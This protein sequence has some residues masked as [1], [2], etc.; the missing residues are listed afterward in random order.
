MM[1]MTDIRA[2]VAVTMTMM[3][4]ACREAVAGA[5]RAAGSEI[6]KATPKPLAE[7]GRNAKAEATA[8][9]ALA[10]MT[11]TDIRAGVA[12]AMTTTIAACR[13]AVADAAKAVGLV[14]LVA[15]PRRLGVAGK[16]AVKL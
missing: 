1:T 13:E 3:I 12:V 10:M 2:G 16:I 15:T 11:M 5:V 7:A 8:A 4:A 9:E 14:I 6:R